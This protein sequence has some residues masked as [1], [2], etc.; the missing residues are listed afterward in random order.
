[1]IPVPSFPKIALASM[2]LSGLMQPALAQELI[3][4]AEVGNIM[5]RYF[6]LEMTGELSPEEVNGLVEQ[7]L[8]AIY[9]AEST[10]VSMERLAVLDASTEQALNDPYAFEVLR[11][12]MRYAVED[13]DCFRATFFGS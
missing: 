4:T 9:G 8:V 12:M 1:M 2:I 7:D 13:D 10:L 6:C 11:E 3:P 5:G